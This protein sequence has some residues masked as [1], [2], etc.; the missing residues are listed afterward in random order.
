MQTR[1]T[2]QAHI[3]VPL[4]CG[5]MYPCSN[6]ELIAA[7]SDAGGLGIVQPL[8]LVYVHGYDFKK[9][10]E[11]IRK[12]TSKPYGVNILVEKSSSLYEKRMRHYL[13]IAIE[14]GC[15]FFITAL[16]NPKWVVDL[17]KQVNGVVYHDVVERKWALKALEHGVDG[18]I[19]VNNAAGGH[20][21]K[22]SARELYNELKDFNVPL[23]YAGGVGDEQD[24]LNAM[25]L[26]YD[27]VQMGTRFIA[28]NECNEKE[29]YKK[30]ICDAEAK[31]IVLTERVTGVPLSVINTPYVQKIG[32]KVGPIARFLLQH[33]MTKHWMRLWYGFTA[34]RNF[35]RISN[36]GG[37][38]KDYFQAGKSVAHIK[39]IESAKT[40]VERFKNAL[41]TS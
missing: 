24:F 17:V 40:I 16:G 41:E 31:D 32:T 27:G 2:H 12:L 18:L 13:E 23:I 26:G 35:K 1:F 19:C 14:D 21:G 6:P 9:G 33:R 4:I 3:E 34:F 38:S 39:K 5:A 28:T 37:S 15:R 7:V 11:Y 30:A 36:E 10:L 29:E 22:K 8:S 25:A 20:A